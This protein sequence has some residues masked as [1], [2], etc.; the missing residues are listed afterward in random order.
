MQQRSGNICPPSVYGILLDLK[1]WCLS[2]SLTSATSGGFDVG[3]KQGQHSHWM[4][5]W[6]ISILGQ[7]I[8]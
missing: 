6:V 5:V 4:L 2:V 7:E 3:G 1:L 8:H